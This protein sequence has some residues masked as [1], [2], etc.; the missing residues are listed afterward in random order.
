MIGKLKGKS[1]KANFLKTNLSGCSKADLYLSLMT[2]RMRRESWQQPDQNRIRCKMQLQQSSPKGIEARKEDSCKTNFMTG[3]CSGC[4][5]IKLNL[6]F[7]TVS[8]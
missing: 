5:S 6:F 4:N 2:R 7:G 1:C 3:F 8:M